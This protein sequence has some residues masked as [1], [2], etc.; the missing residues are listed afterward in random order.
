MATACPVDLDQQKL[1]AEIQ[2]AMPKKVED[3]EREIIL[4]IIRLDQRTVKEVMRPLSQMACLSDALSIE[5]MASASR[6]H[7]RCL[8]RRRRNIDSLSATPTA[9]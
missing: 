7:R 6:K 9:A 4:Q 1:R 8:T 2:K 5:E 3:A